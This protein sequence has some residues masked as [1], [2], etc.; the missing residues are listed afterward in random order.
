MTRECL[1]ETR[2]AGTWRYD[3]AHPHGRRNLAHLQH[4]LRRRVNRT[5]NRRKTAGG[6]YGPRS[7]PRDLV[8]II[9]WSERTSKSDMTGALSGLAILC[10]TAVASAAPATVASSVMTPETEAPA[11]SVSQ[12]NAGTA[13]QR[14][15]RRR[16]ATRGD[17][18]QGTR[19]REATRSNSSSVVSAA[20]AD[21][22]PD[23]IRLHGA[24]GVPSRGGELSL[25]LSLIHI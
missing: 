18:R 23:C 24:V 21:A 8:R 12:T 25:D 1:A 9:I 6:R 13:A 5:R 17:A 15:A 19:R 16:D 10:F 3:L 14:K 2:S 22:P 7:P 20:S 4:P 11:P